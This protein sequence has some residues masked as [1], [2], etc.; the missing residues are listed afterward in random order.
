[1]VETPTM[2]ALN[3]VKR[4]TKDQDEQQILTL[5][6]HEAP[7]GDEYGMLTPDEWERGCNFAEWLEKNEIQAFE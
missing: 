1:M 6:L 4:Y 3:A 7:I 2:A 5:W